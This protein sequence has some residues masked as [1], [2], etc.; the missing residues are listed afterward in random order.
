MEVQ[1]ASLE[2]VR[3]GRDGRM[4]LVSSDVGGVAAE[5]RR[6]DPTLRLKYAEAGEHWVV[7]RVHRQG[8]ACADDDP[9]RTEELV[10]TA[11]ECDQRIV[12][13]V[14][15]IHPALNNGYDFVAEVDRI[16][17]EAEQRRRTQGRELVEERGE[18]LAHAIRKDLGG[19]Y[20]GRATPH[21]YGRR[22]P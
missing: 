13:R 6:L 20:K 17:R 10:L 3:R 15:E 22:A 8:E 14:M 21:R 19:R 9:D 16:N 11:Q 7:Y 1:P 2:Q 4:V 12:R 5:L 18:R